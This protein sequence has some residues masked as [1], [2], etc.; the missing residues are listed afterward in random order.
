[1]DPPFVPGENMNTKQR[2]EEIYRLRRE[3]MSF[4]EIA[5]RFGISSAYVQ[6]IWREQID[7]FEKWPPL[8]QMLPVRLQL[9]L[10]GAF[11]SEI[12]EHPEKLAS[13]DHRVFLRMRNVGTRS[14]K[15]LREALESLGDPAFQEMTMTDPRCQ[16]YLE[17]GKAVLRNYFDYSTKR[18]LDDSEYISAVRVIIESIAK[19]MESSSVGRWSNGELTQK[20]K[21]FN[22]HL[23]KDL[24]IK[25]AKEDKD[26]EKDPVDAEKERRSAGYTF[27][28]IYRHGKHPDETPVD[29]EEKPVDEISSPLPLT[30]EDGP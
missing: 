27:D 1:V 8:K 18:S 29:K 16:V 19:E 3:G 9:A 25:H 10:Q 15:Q 14:I 13:M 12:F 28:Y 2:N 4:S 6:Q 30:G 7:N 26:P 17:I 11:G 5:G 22:R 20:L 21:S 24:W 23:Y